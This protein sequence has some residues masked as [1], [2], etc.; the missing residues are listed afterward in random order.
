MG[1]PVS[2]QM[3]GVANKI[4]KKKD[5]KVSGLFDHMKFDALFAVM[6]FSSRPELEKVSASGLGRKRTIQGGHR[7][8]GQ[9]VHTHKI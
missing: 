9:H 5:V 2:L 1:K 6:L 4:C 3:W 7:K 8:E